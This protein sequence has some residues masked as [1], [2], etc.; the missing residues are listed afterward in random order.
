MLEHNNPAQEGIESAAKP[1]IKTPK[2]RSKRVV[3]NSD[4][5]PYDLIIT[6]SIP[7]TGGTRE[8]QILAGDVRR[9]VKLTT[10]K[11]AEI[12]HAV[13]RRRGSDIQGMNVKDIPVRKM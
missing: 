9:F 1:V 12:V 8:A 11:D 2:T 4:Q 7:A 6:L 3:S 5:G 10:V 13:I